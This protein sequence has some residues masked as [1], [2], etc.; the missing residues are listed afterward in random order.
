MKTIILVLLMVAGSLTAQAKS[1]ELVLETKTVA[2]VDGKAAEALFYQMTETLEDEKIEERGYVLRVGKDIDC[3]KKITG[4]DT[5]EYN[6][7]LDVTIK[8]IKRGEI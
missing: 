2:S 7:L 4:Q 3:I 6:C 8:N 1:N 5:A